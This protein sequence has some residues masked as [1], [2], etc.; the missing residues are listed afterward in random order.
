VGRFY[1]GDTS[2]AI[3]Q[4][5]AVWFVGVGGSF[6][7]CGAS[8]MVMLWPTIDGIMLLTGNHRDAQGRPLRP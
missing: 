6:F 5:A 2:T 7:T 4:L 8:L 3:A 1:I